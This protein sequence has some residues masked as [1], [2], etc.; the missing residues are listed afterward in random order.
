MNMCLGRKGQGT[1]NICDYLMVYFIYVEL[2]ITNTTDLL[3][4]QNTS[5][6]NTRHMTVFPPTK[7]DLIKY[8]P[9][10]NKVITLFLYSCIIKFQRRK[11]TEIEYITTEK[12]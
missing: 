7:F 9:H 2:K 11:T 4:L 8:K 10:C 5:G 1:D 6:F 12:C 3:L